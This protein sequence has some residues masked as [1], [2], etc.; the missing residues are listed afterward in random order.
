MANNS[1]K[2]DFFETKQGNR[3][4]VMFGKVALGPHHLDRGEKAGANSCKLR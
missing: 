4:A 2:M 3:P 1:Q